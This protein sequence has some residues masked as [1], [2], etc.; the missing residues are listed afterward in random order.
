MTKDNAGSGDNP[1]ERGVYKQGARARDTMNRATRNMTDLVVGV[2][3]AMA[4]GARTFSE[5]VAERAK[6]TA[7]RPTDFVE[8]GALTASRVFSSLAESWQTFYESL[9]RDHKATAAVPESIDYER[10]ADLI[11]ER[12]KAADK[13]PPEKK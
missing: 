11:A 12:M 5:T 1:S 9:V 4:D 2:S 6:E 13:P 7:A 10:L 3:K 8:A